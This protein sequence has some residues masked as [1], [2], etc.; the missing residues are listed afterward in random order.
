MISQL[1]LES[2]IHAH[3][4]LVFKVASRIIW[5]ASG[6]IL[7]LTGVLGKMG[8]VLAMV[9]DPVVAGISIFSFAT[10]AAVGVGSLRSLQS[11]ARNELILGVALLLG[12]T[13]P[14]W[15]KSNLDAL[16][17]G[18]KWRR[19]HCN[20]NVINYPSWFQEALKQI[21]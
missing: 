6:I 19:N 10:V 3:F 15:A 2:Q 17:T 1:I 16:E 9:P 21:K 7:V 8:A 20:H 12:F 4:G 11:S 13:I 18:N 5:I 14:Q